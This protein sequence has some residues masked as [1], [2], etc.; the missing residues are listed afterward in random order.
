MP[1]AGAKRLSAIG[2]TARSAL[3]EMRRLLGVLREDAHSDGPVNCALNP[4]YEQLGGLVDRAREA[5][6]SGARLILAGA[7]MSLDPGVELAAYR[8]VQEALTNARRHAPGAGVDV[9]LRY[10]TGCAPAPDPRQRDRDHRRTPRSAGHGLSGMRERAAAVGRGASGPDPPPAAVSSSRRRCRAEASEAPGEPGTAPAVR[11]VVADDHEVVRPA[12]PSLLDSQPEFAVVGTAADGNEA[13]QISLELETRRDPDGHPDAGHGRHRGHRAARGGR[14]TRA[15]RPRAD[16]VRSRRVR[17]RGAPGRRQRVSAQGCDGRAAVRR[18]ARDRG[19][20]GAARARRDA[21]AD[22][23]VRRQRP[24]SRPAPAPAL[25]ELTPRETEVLRLV[26]EGLSNPEIAA[27]L[28]V[29]EETVKTHVS[30]VLGKLGLRDRTQ[31]VV[32]AYESGLVIP[33]S[34]PLGRSA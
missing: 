13:V 2:D 26:A 20:R 1:A 14:A 3:T 17:L 15:A 23:R 4:A 29:T 32:A 8:I 22:Q 27:R 34:R 16:H 24:T 21:P 10:G 11:I 5:S 19:G 25:D 12:S 7:P 6:G 33:A 31:A 18:R 30:H 9:E 28:V